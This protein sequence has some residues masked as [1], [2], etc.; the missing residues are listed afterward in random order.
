MA[1]ALSQALSIKERV[2]M[3]PIK[4]GMVIQLFHKW[5]GMLLIL[6]IG[7]KILSGYA[8]IGATAV[9]SPQAGYLVH[10]SAWLDI[11]LL[12]IVIL[13]IAYGIL[14]NVTSFQTRNKPSVF[15]IT[16]L[17]AVAVFVL[18]SGLVYIF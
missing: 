2:K 13:H 9:L 14:K 1:A 6:L 7:M 16:T 17:V 5:S 10:T 11:P 12:L 18:I 15:W 3:K 8:S 4:P